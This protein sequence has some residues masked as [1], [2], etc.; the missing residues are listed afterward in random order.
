MDDDSGDNNKGDG[1][2]D[3]GVKINGCDDV[4]CDD[5]ESIVGCGDD[6]DGDNGDIIGD[7]NGGND[8]YFG[9]SKTKVECSDMQL[10]M[11][12]IVMMMVVLIMVVVLILMTMIVMEMMLILMVMIMMVMAM[13]L[14]LVV[15]IKEMVV[16]MKVIM[17]MVMLKMVPEMIVMI[18]IIL[19]L[20]MI[21][22]L[23]T[24]FCNSI[25]SAFPQFL[26]QIFH[27][28]VK[29]ASSV[30]GSVRT[31]SATTCRVIGLYEPSCDLVVSSICWFHLFR[32]F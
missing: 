11:M 27:F 23:K 18:K 2:D 3:G 28:L 10:V 19:I 6:K 22:V 21:M 1:V 26:M 25:L 16:I 17:L 4:N 9:D 20:K 7:T 31:C 8:I 24:T 32:V 13:M 30:P 15:M 5:D 29:L 14:V 12:V